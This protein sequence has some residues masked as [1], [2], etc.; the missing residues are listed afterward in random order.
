MKLKIWEMGFTDAFIAAFNHGKRIGIMDA[1][2][3]LNQA[4]ENGQ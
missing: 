2:E 1:I 3:Y 4:N